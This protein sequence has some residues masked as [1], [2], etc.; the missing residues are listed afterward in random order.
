MANRSARLLESL[1][2]D[3]IL[4]AGYGKQPSP[5]DRTSAHSRL[6]E[7]FEDFVGSSY[8]DGKLDLVV[9]KFASGDKALTAR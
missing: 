9:S 4:I 1:F 7:I 3:P 8:Y 5:Q 2:S 6:L